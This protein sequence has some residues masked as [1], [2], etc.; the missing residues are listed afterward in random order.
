MLETLGVVVVALGGGCKGLG[1]GRGVRVIR[2][3]SDLR[4]RW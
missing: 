3:L 2:G 1:E 4:G